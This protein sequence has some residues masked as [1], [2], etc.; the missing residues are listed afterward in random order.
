MSTC[1]RALKFISVPESNSGPGLRGF[2]Q[3][4][5]FRTLDGRDTG[6]LWLGV[7]KQAEPQ[8]PK[9]LNPKTLKTLNPK[10]LNPKPPKLLAASILNSELPGFAFY[11]SLDGR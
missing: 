5:S 10:P 3:D 2:S 8:N 7:Y 11:A 9:P 1:L 4:I 6:Q